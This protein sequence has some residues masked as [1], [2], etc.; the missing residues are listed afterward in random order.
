MLQYY[1]GS[2]TPDEHIPASKGDFRPS[3]PA[4]TPCT[5]ASLPML[6]LASCNRNQHLAGRSRAILPTVVAYFSKQPL[7]FL[8]GVCLV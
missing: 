5:L 2:A 4:F 3:Y 8:I 6:K 7:S 1:G